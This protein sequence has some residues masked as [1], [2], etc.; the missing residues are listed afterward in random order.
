MSIRKLIRQELL[1][2]PTYL[3]GGDNAKIR[4]HA[5]ESPWSPAGFEDISLN[6]YPDYILQQELE[7]KLAARY[8]VLPEQ[9]VLSRGSDEGIDILTRLFLSAGLDA[10]MQFPPTFPMYAFYT[11]LQNAELISCPLDMSNGFKLTLD[12]INNHWKPNCKIIMICTPNNPTGHA[13]DLEFIESVCETYINRAVIIVDEAYIEF[14][15]RQSATSLIARYDNLIVLRTLSKA[16]GLA[17]LR[18]G[19]LIAQEQVVQAIKK[20][21]AP[22]TLSSVVIKLAL[23]ALE[24]D[25]W[26]ATS[27]HHILESRQQMSDE[28]AKLPFIERVYPSESN[29]LLVKT[30][31]AKELS[32]WCL[33]SDIAVRDFPVASP[34]HDHLRITVGDEEQNK[35]L[36]DAF[37]SFMS[38]YVSR[39]I[40]EKNSFN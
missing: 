20:V 6:R 21:I 28:L 8:Q 16:A 39:C 13:V 38:N 24:N 9:L 23:E 35:L 29:F 5:N 4:L 3:P 17:G 14:A 11:H 27:V 25:E 37:S 30:N 32:A 26:L 10:F 36:L 12:H 19:C 40:D 34:L 1:N 33:Q 31:Y 7:Q 15:K 2:T 22:F 18:I